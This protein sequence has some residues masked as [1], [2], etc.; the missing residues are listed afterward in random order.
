MKISSKC[1]VVKMQCIIVLYGLQN[2]HGFSNEN[3]T[4]L[5]LAGVFISTVIIF[6]CRQKREDGQRP[7]ITVRLICILGEW[8][9]DFGQWLGQ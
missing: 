2:L 4:S 7:V 1:L 8:T 3:V 9:A 5:W 6:Y